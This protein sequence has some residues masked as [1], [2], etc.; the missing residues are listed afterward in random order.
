MLPDI[1]ATLREDPVQDGG[2]CAAPLLNQFIDILED[3]EVL[4]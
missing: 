3:H 1:G 4:Q 2:R